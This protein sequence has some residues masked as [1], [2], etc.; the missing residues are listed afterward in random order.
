VDRLV[1]AIALALAV[2]LAVVGTSCPASPAAAFPPLR[3]TRVLVLGD[4][5][6]KGADARYPEALPGR[7]LVVD[8]EVNR[9]TGAGADVVARIGADWD[10]VVILLGH[11]DGG[12]PGV[13]QPAARRLLD[14]LR[15]VR[16]VVWLTIHE[17]RPY[18][19]DVNRFIDSLRSEYP[20]LS[21]ADWNAVANAHPEAVARDGL[22]LTGAGAALM[23]D[24][25]AQQVEVGEWLWAADLHRLASRATTTTTAP[26]T[27]TT[28]PPT[29][30]PPTTT[31]TTSTTEAAASTTSPRAST[32]RRATDVAPTAATTEPVADP[33]TGAP[34]PD[35]GVGEVATLAVPAIGA[36]AGAT[37]LVRRRRRADR[38][39]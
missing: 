5:V 21:T 26:P 15:G 1:K 24:L 35:D 28:A 38:P 2:G 27:T 29:T 33:R 36:L 4:S 32:T 23:A 7:D 31:S 22:H 6:M 12:T 34:A 30:A 9:S 10:V 11:N 3:P 19:P 13:Y 17:V 37:F 25:V 18:Y 14:Q 39:S 20:N 8:T 16:R